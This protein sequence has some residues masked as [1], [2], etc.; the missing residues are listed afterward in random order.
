MK[1]STKARDMIM[2]AVSNRVDDIA[3]RVAQK[4]RFEVKIFSAHSFDAINIF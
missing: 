3:T 2:N 4:A 1:K